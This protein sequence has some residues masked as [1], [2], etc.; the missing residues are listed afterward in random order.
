MRK[1]QN[2]EMKSVKAGA[3]PALVECICAFMDGGMSYN[4]ARNY[5]ED[6]MSE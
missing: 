1:M 4:E 3:D 2:Q 6:I 5:C